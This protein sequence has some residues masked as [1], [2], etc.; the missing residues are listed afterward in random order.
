[1]VNSYKKRIMLTKS[2]FDYL[3]TSKRL[4]NVACDDLTG[5]ASPMQPLQFF[6]TWILTKGLRSYSL[7][8]F[9]S[10]LVHLVELRVILLLD[11]A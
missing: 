7:G 4:F 8:L 1:M 6:T 10:H 5:P 9:A 2:W 3:A 11:H